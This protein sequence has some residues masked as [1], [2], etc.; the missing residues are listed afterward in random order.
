MATV[1]KPATFFD[2]P[3]RLSPPEVLAERELVAKMPHLFTLL[4]GYPEPAVLV[5]AHR[6]IVV[7]NDKI[8]TLLGMDPAA[9][10][11]LR[12]GEALNCDYAFEEPGGCGTTEACVLCGAARAIR[13]TTRHR[14]TARNE[15]RISRTTPEGPDALDLRVWTTP[16]EIEGEPFTI[17]AVRDTTDEQRRK[18]L[19]RLFFH[20]V[21][22]TAGSLQG[23]MQVWHDLPPEEAAELSTRAAQ[24][25]SQV[26]EEIQS[27]RDL[28]AAE[29][30]ELTPQLELLKVAEL[31]ASVAESY[32]HHP[33]AENRSIVTRPMSA[34]LQL[35]TDPVLFR[36]VVGTLVKNALEAS[37]AGQAVTIWGDLT[38]R[39]RL[40]VHNS[41]AMPD[42]V[43]L[44]VFQRS[45]STKSGRG[46]GVGTYSARLLVEKYLHGH[47]SFVSAPE[48]GTV[49]TIDLP[50]K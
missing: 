32:A 10:A 30:G 11:S 20:D 31:I 40:H 7:A 38:D 45:F 21:L 46:R 6:Q 27:Q 33:V 18:V 28:S 37:E 44:Q 35:T 8:C 29:R 5:D 42:S 14:T 47:I 23:L 17:V 49:F 22:N 25:A 4:D 50:I 39:M 3:E 2:S 24:M 41:S 34:E 43:R 12:I 13:T 26:V 9:L 19:E 48:T 1:E 16:I 36:R 15:C